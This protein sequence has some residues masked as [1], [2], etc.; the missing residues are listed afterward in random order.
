[1]SEL[2]KRLRKHFVLSEE[3]DDNEVLRITKGTYSRQ[4]IELDIA[5]GV[6]SKAIKSAAEEARNAF[7]AFGKAVRRHNKKG[8]DD[9][10]CK[11]CHKNPVHIDGECVD[12]CH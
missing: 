12:C 10:L 3:L 7:I 9:G 4:V 6:F 5:T 1:M 2:V 8:I 11:V